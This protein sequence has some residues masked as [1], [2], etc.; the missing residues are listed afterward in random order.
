MRKIDQSTLTHTFLER[1][2]LY[3]LW[4]YLL[5][6]F[7]GLQESMLDTC[8]IHH[9]KDRTFALL[10]AHSQTSVKPGWGQLLL[11]N[12]LEI[13]KLKI[14][15]TTTITT[16]EDW[17]WV[18]TEK[19]LYKVTREWVCWWIYLTLP[20]GYFVIFHRKLWEDD[21]EFAHHQPPIPIS[22]VCKCAF[23]V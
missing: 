5:N 7:R 15:R 20:F 22:L 11:E 16:I 19:V 10:T 21:I 1:Y 23:R 13:S 4:Y 14:H 18:P 6:H 2:D 17:E 12:E 9:N 3:Y 8:W